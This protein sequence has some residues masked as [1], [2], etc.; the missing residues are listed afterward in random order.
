MGRAK[1]GIVILTSHLKA[2]GMGRRT[3]AKLNARV[4]RHAVAHVAAPVLEDEAIEH[5]HRVLR[6]PKA[7]Q[8]K[9]S[10]QS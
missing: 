8:H 4:V 2:G 6:V 9:R 1:K 3:L 10:I 7:R 5:S